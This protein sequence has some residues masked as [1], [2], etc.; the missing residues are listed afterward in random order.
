MR[1][2]RCAECQ[3]FMV[4]ERNYWKCPICHTWIDDEIAAPFDESAKQATNSFFEYYV[5]KGGG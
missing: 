4:K 1:K 2:I 5:L 3:T